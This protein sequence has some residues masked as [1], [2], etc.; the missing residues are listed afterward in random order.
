ME[1]YQQLW[2]IIVLFFSIV[3]LLFSCDAMAIQ[4]KTLVMYLPFEEGKGDE[5]KDISGNNNVGKIN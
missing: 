5:T 2:F 1:I 4:D 3:I